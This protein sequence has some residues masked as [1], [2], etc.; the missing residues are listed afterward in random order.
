[1]EISAKAVEASR[2]VNALLGL[3]D[4]DQEALLEVIEDYFTTSS[5]PERDESE[6]E[7]DSDDYNELMDGVSNVGWH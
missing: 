2:A 6:D 3:R 1:M 7:S 5:S 4:G